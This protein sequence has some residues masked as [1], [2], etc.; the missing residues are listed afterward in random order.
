MEQGASS[1]HPH[2]EGQKRALVSTTETEADDDGW[3]TT[4]C[5]FTLTDDELPSSSNNNNNNHHHVEESKNGDMLA[6]MQPPNKQVVITIRSLGVLRGVML[7]RDGDI[8]ESGQLI[9]PGSTVLSLYLMCRSSILHNKSVVELG[10]GCG[11]SGLLAAKFARQVVLT[12]RNPKVI[13]IIRDN[14]QRNEV[15]ETA[16]AVQLKWGEGVENF[17]KLFPAPFDLVIGSDIIYPGYSAALIPILFGTVNALLAN[18]GDSR[19]IL[20]FIPR[21]KKLRQQVMEEADRKGFQVQFV[22][23]TEY[24]TQKV[25]LDAEILVLGRKA[26]IA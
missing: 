14:I 22:P 1:S 6:S 18:T 25:P 9:W 5:T 2:P 7:D 15:Q 26:I 4:T 21:E 3:I 20:S 24:T 13:D 16:C 23:S 10:A 19:L 17:K 11:V 8:D 12:D